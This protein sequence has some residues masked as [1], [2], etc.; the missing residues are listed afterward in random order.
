MSRLRTRIGVTLG[1]VAVLS[2]LSTTREQREEARHRLRRY[3]L[4]ILAIAVGL[5][6]LIIFY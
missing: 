1:A 4:L 5:W 2:I 6:A 3:N